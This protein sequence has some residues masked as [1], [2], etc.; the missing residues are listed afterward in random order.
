[1][2]RMMIFDEIDDERERQAAKWGGVNTGWGTGDC[3]S[4]D[5]RDEVKSVV[6]TEECGEVARAVL[7]R[8]APGLRKELV[9]VAAVCV[10]W[11]EAL[12]RQ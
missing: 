5:M 11:L 6:L 2:T 4:H 3:S 10:A 7:E 1:M 9:Q 12:E 8:D